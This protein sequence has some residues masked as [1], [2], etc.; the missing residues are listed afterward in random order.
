[1]SQPEFLL[2]NI[3][4]ENNAAVLRDYA[5]R[6]KLEDGINDLIVHNFEKLVQLLYRIDV[7]EAKLKA[8]LADNTNEDAAKIIAA[9]IIERQLQKIKSR[10]EF[11]KNNDPSEERW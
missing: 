5:F 7:N 3:L 8:M 9:L 6:Q 4:Q 11:K 2:E 1:M 10:A